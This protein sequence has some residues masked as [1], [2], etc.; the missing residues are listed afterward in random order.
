VY[1][2]NIIGNTFEAL[3]GAIY[4]DGGIDLAETFL[5]S[6]IFNENFNWEEVDNK[7]WDYKSKLI[8]YA[9][10]NVISLEYITIGEERTD[11]NFTE[12]EVL[13][14][15]NGKD[16]LTAK[17]LSKKKAEQLASKMVFED[18]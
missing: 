5:S 14:K 10:K 4:L 17:G 16:C 6:K 9:Q 3:I 15:L 13:I 7:I 18:L 11:N 2:T 8:Q 12:F 1:E